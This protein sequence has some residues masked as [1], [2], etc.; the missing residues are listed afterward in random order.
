MALELP[1]PLAAHEP[2]EPLAARLEPDRRRHRRV[3]LSLLG[4]FMRANKQEYPCKLVDISVGGAALMSPVPVED[5][6]RVVV[7]LDVL[8]GL[9]GK[10]VRQLPGG[11]AMELSATPHKREKL[12]AQ[13]T[14]LINR[15]ELGTADGRRHERIVPRKSS[16]TLEVEGDVITPCQVLDVSISGASIETEARPP[17]GTEVKLG[18]LRSRVVRHH[19]TGLA[20]RF[21]DIQQPTALRRYFG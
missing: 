15:H 10:V 5:G 7:Y 1:E 11:F 8:G 2:L 12:A 16:S 13:I 6:E 20:V 18:K 19:E 14:W 17:I 3:P 9:E 4:R 21:L